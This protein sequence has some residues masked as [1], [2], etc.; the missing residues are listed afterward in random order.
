[1]KVDPK[2]KGMFIT[3]GALPVAFYFGNLKPVKGGKDTRGNFDKKDCPFLYFS[4]T[5]PKTYF[6]DCQGLTK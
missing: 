3:D 5:K 1:M 6:I 2:C 4:K